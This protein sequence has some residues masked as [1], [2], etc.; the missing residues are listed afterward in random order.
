MKQTKQ[1]ILS[2]LLLVC[3]P[4]IVVAQ[5]KADG[6]IIEDVACAANPLS[7]YD[8]YV[9][10]LRQGYAEE[11]EAAKREGFRMETPGNLADFVLSRQEFE[12]RRAYAGFECHHIKY[13]S[14][15]LKVSGYLWKPKETAGP[16]RPLI[17][18]NRGGNREFGAV[19]PWMWSGFYPF[20]E[21]GF[22]VVASQYRGNDGGEGREEF[23]GADVRDV[24]NL[25]PL[26][27]SLGYVDMN[28]VF[29]LGASRGGMM[30]YLALKQGMSVNAAA[31]LSGVSDVFALVKDR[32]E[33]REHV[34]KELIPDFDKRA[35]EAM[36]DRS[37]V[38][39]ADRINVP[40]LILHGSADWRADPASQALAF[41]LK[42]Q[43]K[44]KNYQLIVYAGDNH[45]LLMNRADSDKRVIDWFKEHLRAK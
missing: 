8:Q 14:D 36:R 10:R 15:G 28:N 4:S 19:S 5:P 34:L 27:K 9:Q 39:W 6:T 31:V 13:L 38:Y 24:L 23:G 29:L 17:I 42:L 45:G 35:D 33:M 2:L 16:L 43:E 26:A 1:S 11:V 21:Q 18:F 32:P 41:A 20:L 30:T 7:S 44:H 12:R 3:A 40:L 37:A 25:L 22:V